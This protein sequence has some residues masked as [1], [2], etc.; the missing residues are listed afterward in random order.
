M[1]RTRNFNEQTKRP[2]FVFHCLF[3]GKLIFLSLRVG[4]FL[5][6][7]RQL[8]A[9]L[10]SRL[11]IGQKCTRPERDGKTDGWLDSFALKNILCTVN[12]V[13]QLWSSLFGRCFLAGFVGCSWEATAGDLIAFDSTSSCYNSF[14]V[15]PDAKF[16]ASTLCRLVERIP[17]SFRNI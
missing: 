4:L 1:K 2:A 15:N 12:F 7:G 17:E 9:F 13:R 8:S 3:C 5:S 11:F 6:P 16:N 14:Q 10:Q